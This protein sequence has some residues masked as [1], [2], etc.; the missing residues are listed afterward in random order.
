MT[1]KVGDKI[2]SVKLKQM[3]PDGVK[4]VQTDEF[5]KGK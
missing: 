1:I 2:P 4:D 5:F 3:T